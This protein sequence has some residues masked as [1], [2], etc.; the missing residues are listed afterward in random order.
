MAS[1]Y[2]GIPEVDGIPDLDL[3]YIDPYF[4]V[5]RCLEGYRQLSMKLP[6][7]SASSALVLPSG[8]VSEARIQLGDKLELRDAVTGSL[9][10]GCAALDQDPSLK[11]A[12]EST[13]HDLQDQPKP[14]PKGL[15]RI[16]GRLLSPKEKPK[17]SDRRKAGRHAIPGL[18]A[19]FSLARLRKRYGVKSISTEGF[20]VLTE[21]RWPPGTSITVGLQIINP[22]SR[23]IEAMISVQSKVIWVGTD[24]V[25]FAFD[26]D[27]LHRN[28]QL[29]IT[30]V[31]ELQQLK[32]FLQMIKD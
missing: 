32:K 25:G 30:S 29:T 7:I 18:V 27:P 21:E 12:V 16:L 8:R 31:E 23:Q 14:Q 17:P 5:L 4:R 19:Y 11:V 28:R 9:W 20:Y 2:R 15:R 13:N 10:G 26:D 22:T 1:P 3:V 6:D 24:G